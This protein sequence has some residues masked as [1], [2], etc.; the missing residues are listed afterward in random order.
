M[1]SDIEVLENVNFKELKEL[2][3]QENKISDIGVLEKVKFEKI[4]KIKFSIEFYIRY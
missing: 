4:R 2:Y 3:L 1:I